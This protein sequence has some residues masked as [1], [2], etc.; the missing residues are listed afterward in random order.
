MEFHVKPFTRQLKS[1]D[2]SVKPMPPIHLARN[3]GT[4]RRVLVIA[5]IVLPL[6]LGDPASAAKSRIALA[7]VQPDRSDCSFTLHIGDQIVL[8][9]RKS[10]GD[11]NMNIDNRAYSLRRSKS[12]WRSGSVTVSYT[13]NNGYEN[14]D[15][16]PLTIRKGSQQ[17][18][19][20]VE[21]YGNCS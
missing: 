9:E 13:N 16:G 10:T 20:D 21:F 11:A 7:T 15:Y 8:W 12:G 4:L 14:A 3:S 17:R 19:Y 5:L 2:I 6:K 18:T 1:A